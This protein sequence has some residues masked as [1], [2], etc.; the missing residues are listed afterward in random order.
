MS[1]ITKLEIAGWHCERGRRFARR[2][3]QEIVDD[4]MKGLREGLANDCKAA[5]R[6]LGPDLL[7]A[8]NPA[9]RDR[10]PLLQDV[11]S[12]LYYALSPPSQED[13]EGGD[14]NPAA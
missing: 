12:V 3:V 8:I 1:V 6:G 14:G 9:Y 5:R 10:V 7:A 11:F 4:A 13:N 2:E